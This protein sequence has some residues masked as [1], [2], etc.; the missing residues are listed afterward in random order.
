MLARQTAQFVIK[1]DFVEFQAGISAG[2]HEDIVHENMRHF[3][4]I[5]NFSTA[6]N[7]ESA[8]LSPKSTMVVFDFKF[9]YTHAD[10]DSV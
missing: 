4:A 2:Q 5:A 1:I 7:H 6:G 8:W 10:R 9:P 3:L